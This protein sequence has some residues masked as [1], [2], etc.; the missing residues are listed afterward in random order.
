MITIYAE[1]FDVGMRIACALSEFNF[2]GKIIPVDKVD[3][4]KKSLETAF[5]NKGVIEINW[6]GQ[7]TFIT[8]GQGHLLELKQASDYDPSYRYWSNIPLPFFRKNYEIKIKNGYDFKTRKSTGKPDEKIK[9][10]LTLIKDLF[11]KS[12]YIINATDDD[13]EGELIFALVYE[14]TKSKTPYK[15]VTLASQTEDGFIKAFNNLKDS[16]DVKAK[17]NAGR[18]RQIADFVVGANLTVGVTLKNHGGEMYSV[19]RV[20]TPVLN[21]IVQRDLEIK[22]FVSEKF[23]TINSELDKDGETFTVKHDERFKTEDEANS[24]IEKIQGVDAK[25]QEVETKMVKKSP[26]LLH[27]LTSLQK[28]CNSILGLSAS[29]TLAYVQK[30]YESGYTTYPRTSSRHLNEDMK[31]DIDE[32]LNNF[33]DKF[34]MLKGRRRFEK[35]YFDDSKV[36]SHYAIVPTK[37]EYS[38]SSDQTLNNVYELI[39]RS[40]VMSQLDDALIE[41]TSAIFDIGGY[42]FYTN[43]SVIKKAGFLEMVKVKSPDQLPKISEGETLKSEPFI[44]EGKTTP[45]QRLN[46]SSLLSMM[47]NVGSE[48]PELKEILNSKDGIGTEATRANIIKTLIDRGYAKYSGKSIIATEK[49]INFIQALTVEDLKSAEMTAKWEQR[50]NKIE[51]GKDDMNKFIQDIESKTKEWLNQISTM[52]PINSGNKTGNKSSNQ[53]DIKCPVC[54]EHLI[55]WKTAWFCPNKD[56]SLN[57]NFLSVN[58]KESDLKDLCEKRKTRYIDGFVSNKTGNKFP[59]PTSL[60][61][62]KDNKLAFE[63]K[64]ADTFK[65]PNCGDNVRGFDWGW[66]C[67]NRD[68]S[69]GKEIAGVEITEKIVK[70]LCSK[71]RTDVLNFINKK[72]EYFPAQLII[73]DDGKVGFEFSD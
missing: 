61:L 56:F 25:V 14:F 4:N 1:K 34:P 54:G 13:R 68:F 69:I 5:K 58:L 7:P 64:E 35:R 12:D 60:V 2:N 43:G 48:N 15:R 41:E 67:K 29:D 52:N 8:W 63:F 16:S 21:M 53:M 19:G 24:I 40:L 10:Q 33:E 37:K 18:A 42:N 17:E 50:L 47:V 26:P 71:K 23:F 39:S 28:E 32:V 30:L 20:Q 31:S 51:D 73:K 38:P 27:N 59:S 55:D 44:K 11:N 46:D 70:Q 49:G 66:G 57:K 72:G 45:P 9:K 22:N 6:K 65:C 36:E 62:G 3:A